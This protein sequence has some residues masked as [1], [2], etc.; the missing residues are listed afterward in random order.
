MIGKQIRE[1]TI[2]SEIGE[3]G[4]GSVYLANHSILGQ[5]AIKALAPQLCIK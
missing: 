5:F 2:A 4:M 3:G 1:Y